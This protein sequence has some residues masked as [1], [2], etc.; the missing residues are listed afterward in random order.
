MTIEMLWAQDD[1]AEVLR[2][3]FGCSS[4]EAVS[5]WVGST[6]ERHWG[7]HVEAPEQVVISDS[8]AL[9]WVSSGDQRL[10]LK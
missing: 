7:I 2:D 9:A 5:A 3:R 1:P 10:L 8:N 4:A 6:A